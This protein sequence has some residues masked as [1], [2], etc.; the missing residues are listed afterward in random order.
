M[1]W[2][3]RAVVGTS[4]ADI[5]RNNALKNGLL[6]VIVDAETQQQLLELAVDQPDAVMRDAEAEGT[7]AAPGL[8]STTPPRGG[9]T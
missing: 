4:F 2:G 3:I 5:F 7:A 8:G 9:Q 1:G 6:P